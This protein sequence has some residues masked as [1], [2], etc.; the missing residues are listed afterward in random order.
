MTGVQTC[1]LPIWVFCVRIPA[2]AGGVF[3]ISSQN[4]GSRVAGR[5]REEG[6]SEGLGQVAAGPGG[7]LCKGAGWR[8]EVISLEC[9]CGNKFRGWRGMRNETLLHGGGKA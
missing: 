6:A 4:L 8:G 1:A 9:A 2:S 5:Q 7:A 3:S